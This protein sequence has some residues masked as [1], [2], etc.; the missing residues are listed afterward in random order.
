M[1]T[2]MALT[3]GLLVAGSASG[4]EKKKVLA[5]VIEHKDKVAF[6]KGTVIKITLADVS[7]AGAPARVIAKKEILDAREFPVKF[8][9]EY[10]PMAIQER[11]S[12]AIQVRIETEGKLKFINDT[13]IAVLTRGA[14]KTDVK[15]PVIAIQR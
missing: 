13:R 15:V 3:L 11:L 10:D 9:L 14:P 7:R 2:I 1:Q 5:G 6:A 12:Y 8:E 4:D